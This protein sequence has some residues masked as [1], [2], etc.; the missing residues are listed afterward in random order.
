MLAIHGVCICYA[1]MYMH[2]RVCVCMHTRMYVNNV[3]LLCLYAC[4]YTCVYACECVHN[5]CVCTCVYACE[6]ML[7]RM[8]ACVCSVCVYACACVYKCECVHNKRVS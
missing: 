7:M 2:L 3:R 5:L 6:C 8:Y 1:C 4:V